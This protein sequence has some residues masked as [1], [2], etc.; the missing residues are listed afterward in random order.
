M[1]GVWDG[2]LKYLGFFEHWLQLKKHHGKN[3]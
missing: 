2:D 1:T 3:I